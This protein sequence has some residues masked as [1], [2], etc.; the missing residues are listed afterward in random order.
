MVAIGRA[1]MSNPQLLLCDELSLGLAPIVVRDI[2]AR[3]ARS[4]R[5]ASRRS[6]SSRTSTQAL[7]IAD[8]VYCM[9][10][11]RMALQGGAG[12]LTRA[13]DRRRLFRGLR[14][15]A[16]GS[17]RSCRASCSAALYAMF[18]IGLAL[19]FG[20]MKL[21]NI[22][23]GDLIVLAGLCR[24]RSSP[25]PLGI[26]PL[27]S[28]VF[29]VPIMA[30]VGYLL[31]RGLFNRTLGGDLMPP[32]LVVVRPLDHHPERLAAAVLRRQ[33]AACRPAASRCRASRSTT[34]ST[35]GVLPL[36]QLALA[37]LVI[38]GLQYPA[39]SHLDRTRL[40]RRLRRSARSRS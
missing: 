17:T 29:V 25:R 35:I 22:A 1:L 31:Q 12:A 19:I 10:E 28:L 11:G 24:A 13:G 37:V 21:V 9:L 40:P 20:V 26:N 16:T 32:L 14:L 6:S 18:A 30:V 36:L 3:C 5:A 8:R 4:S 15:W 38:G 27:V 7:K 23:H 34:R 33:S 2:Y 39:L